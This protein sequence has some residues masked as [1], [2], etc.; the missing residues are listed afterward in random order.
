MEKR[1]PWWVK[2]LISLASTILSVVLI[3]GGL[4]VFV[5]VKY[6]INIF[7]TI[8]QVGQIAKE[9]DAEERFSN[10]FFEEDMATAKTSINEVIPNLIEYS[11][12]DG[13]S[14]SSSVSGTMSSDLKLTGKQVGALLNMLIKNQGK[15]GFNIAGK[16]FN[17]DLIQIKFDNL[18]EKSVEFNVVVKLDISSIKESMNFFPA[19]WIA[20]YIPSNIYISS[21]LIIHKNE[22]AFDY[23][24]ESKSLTINN[25]DEKGTES[26]LKTINTFIKFAT[27]EDLNNSLGGN[28]ANAM[29]GNSETNGFAYSL[30][31]LGATDFDFEKIGDE[32][33]FV[34]KN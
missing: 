26:L 20:G 15:M 14:L 19:N 12:T 29:I 31:D 22:T 1:K 23:T 30:K 4:C 27:V 25:L 17:F 10:L 9:I 3:I 18:Q 7:E 13:Y 5:K 2:L 33:Y 6:D 34:V 11:E 28:F 24:L 21:T 32:I 8:S 16:E